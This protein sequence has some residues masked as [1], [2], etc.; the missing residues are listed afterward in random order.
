MCRTLLDQFGVPS[1]SRDLHEPACLVC[2]I[3]VH[4]VF[5]FTFLT[6]PFSQNQR[7][8]YGKDFPCICYPFD[9]KGTQDLT[10]QTAVLK[11]REKKLFLRT[12]LLHIQLQKFNNFLGGRDLSGKRG[13]RTEEQMCLEYAYRVDV[14]RHPLQ[15]WRKGNANTTEPQRN[16]SINLSAE[17]RWEK[18]PYILK[19]R[20]P[21]QS[22]RK[23]FWEECLMKE[24]NVPGRNLGV[25]F[26]QRA[27]R[28]CRYRLSSQPSIQSVVLQTKENWIKT[29]ENTWLPPAQN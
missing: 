17:Y 6:V 3:C 5:A 7:H 16:L 28:K 12:T 9:I 25:S 13:N 24:W 21:E 18:H 4:L 1:L 11:N 8:T 14:W 23:K 22:P 26:V 15:I 19:G 10:S 20:T 2:N 29:R 27:R